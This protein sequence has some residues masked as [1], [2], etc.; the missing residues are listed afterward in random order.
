MPGMLLHIDGSK[1]A[2]FQDHRHHDLIVVMDDATNQIYEA[3]LVE[4]ESTATVMAALR[5]VVETQ[6]LF[7]ALYSD[8]ASHFRVTLESGGR[9]D[10]TRLTQIGRAMRELGVEMIP[11]Y[12]PQARGRSERGFGTWQGRLPQELRLRGITTVEAANQFLREHYMGELNRRFQKSAAEPGTAFVPLAGQDLDRIFSIQHM[13]KVRHDNTVQY[14]N[15]VLQIEPVSW[16][17]TLAG[18]EVLLREH[19]DGSL[20]LHYGPHCV[21]RYSAQGE[22]AVAGR[23]KTAD[24][25]AVEKTLGGKVK[26]QTFPPSLEIPQSTRD[27]HFPTASATAGST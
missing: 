19:L 20:S 25:G 21:G 1:H 16:R 24:A 5:H 27:S 9:V 2:W 12:S 4:E 13:R 11:A 15:Q 6:G 22:V 10:R 23:K 17:A 18:C 8:R 26:K 7:C 14:Q 3:R